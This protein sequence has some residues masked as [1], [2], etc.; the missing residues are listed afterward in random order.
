[1]LR[2]R[3]NHGQQALEAGKH[4]PVRAKAGTD[5]RTDVSLLKTTTNKSRVLL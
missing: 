4:N 3:Y 2:Y 5:A 1:M